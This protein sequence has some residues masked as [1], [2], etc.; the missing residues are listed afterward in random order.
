MSL[1]QAA[2]CIQ[3]FAFYGYISVV[4]LIEYCQ[5]LGPVLV[6]TQ[7]YLGRKDN[8]DENIIL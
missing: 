4:L 7:W 1:G 6:T 2:I 5:P 3:R 8:F